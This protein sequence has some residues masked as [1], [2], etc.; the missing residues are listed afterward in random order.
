MLHVVT[1][2]IAANLDRFVRAGGVLVL[3]ARSGFKTED[4]LATEGPLPGLLLSLTGARVTGLSTLQSSTPRTWLDFPPERG[5]Y[6]SLGENEIVAES[7]NWPGSYM[8]RGWAD[9]LEPVGARILFRYSRDFYSG[10]AAV[11]LSE[12]GKGKVLYI[13]TLL[14]P[15]FYH[16]MARWVCRW[17]NLETGP[18]IPEGVDYAIRRLGDK[19]VRFLLNFGTAA[20][21]VQLPGSHR[22]LLTNE[23]FSGG[24][25]VPSLDLRVLVR[26]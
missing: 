21:V 19:E 11:T 9:I 17:A 1:P 12:V 8:A 5:L 7:A 14:E 20:S 18:E 16:D 23:S 13:G 22:D 10:S 3:S 24:V 2:A 6:K 15:R 26:P 4:N 25:S